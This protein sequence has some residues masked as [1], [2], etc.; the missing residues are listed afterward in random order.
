MGPPYRYSVIHPMKWYTKYAV[1]PSLISP[2]KRSRLRRP[3]CL[4]ASMVYCRF[5]VRSGKGTAALC[6]L[7]TQF[8]AWKNLSFERL[9][10]Y[11]RRTGSPSTIKWNCYL[12]VVMEVRLRVQTVL[13]LDPVSHE[14]HVAYT[15]LQQD[16]T[17]ERVPC[18]PGWTLRDAIAFFCDWF[19]VDRANI[20]LIRPFLPQRV[21]S[22]DN[23]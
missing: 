2:K 21:E 22:Y 18:A 19:Q 5:V 6:Q 15:V 20:K 14:M 23:Q 11:I 7:L 17:A 9:I 16:V 1:I 12:C 3:C 13:T 4:F 10:S 8:R